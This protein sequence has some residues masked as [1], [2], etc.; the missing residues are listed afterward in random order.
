MKKTKFGIKFG[1]S[2]KFRGSKGAAAGIRKSTPAATS[3]GLLGDLQKLGDSDS[4]EDNNNKKSRAS[5][6][7]EKDQR[8]AAPAEPGSTQ[9]SDPSSNAEPQFYGSGA[10]A[11]QPGPSSRL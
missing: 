6:P 2:A 10:K 5:Q 11:P 7:D 9:Q 3:P 4:D 8:L 1:K